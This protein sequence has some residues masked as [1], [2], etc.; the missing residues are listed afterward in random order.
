MTSGADVSASSL[1]NAVRF[2][3]VPTSLPLKIGIWGVAIIA[4][5]CIVAVLSVLS[6]GSDG[7]SAD[8]MSFL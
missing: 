4:I 3:D 8:R 1:G 6:L 2:V 7:Q 5:G